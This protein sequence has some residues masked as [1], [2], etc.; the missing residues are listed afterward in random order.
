MSYA[1]P[2]LTDRPVITDRVEAFPDDTKTMLLNRVSWGA[3]LAGLAVALVLTVLLNVLGVGIGLSVLDPNNAANNPDPSSF[4]ID[5]AIWWTASG[6]FASFFGGL[7]AGRLYGAHRASTGGWH[8]IVVWSCTTLLLF[9]ILTTG[10]AGIVGGTFNAVGSA[11]GGLGKAAAS[12]APGLAQAADP[13]GALSSG[14]QGQVR[15]L[16]NSNDPKDV[17]QSLTDY[18]RAGAQGDAAAQQQA[19]DKAVA[20]V[21][22]AANISPDEAR[23]RLDQL[24]QRYQ[25]AA[26]KAKQEA[27]QAAEAARKATSRAAIFGFVALMVGALAAFIGGAAGTPRRETTVTRGTRI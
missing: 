16:V 15:D 26:E 5:A 7:V 22:K 2:L 3:I 21:A 11:V 20:S 25:Q 4:S 13:G 6:I 10:L 12:A 23:T 27:A 14:L 19:K 24:Q 18:I 1:N 17:Q 8:G 9:Y